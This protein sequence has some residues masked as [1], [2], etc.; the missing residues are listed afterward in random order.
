[1]VFR[2]Y[3]D[4]RRTRRRRRILFALR[5]RSAPLDWDSTADVR[6]SKTGFTPLVTTQLESRVESH[7][8]TYFV[9]VRIFVV[10]EHRYFKFVIQV[11]RSSLVQA[12]VRQTVRERGV[13]K[14]T[15]P[16]FVRTTVDLEKFCH[17]T[18][19]AETVRQQCRRRR[20]SAYRTYGAQGQYTKAQAPSVRFLLY[21]FVANLLVYYMHVDNK[22]TKWS[23]ALPCMY[24]LITDRWRSV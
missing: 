7:R 10:G 16:I 14:L 21:S 5:Q 15:W 22:S 6:A 4:F 12:Y 17:G 3:C 1:M 11:D 23:L 19:L 24:M 13:V 8:P 20:T 9:A 18:P 2:L